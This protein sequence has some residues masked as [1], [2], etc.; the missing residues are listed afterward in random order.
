VR[1]VDASDVDGDFLRV[2]CRVI[3][4]RG[5]VVHQIQ[6]LAFCQE[7]NQRVIE[8]EVPAIMPDWMLLSSAVATEI[9]A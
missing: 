9:S 4:S 1:L 7:L 6:A 3:V 2:A 5:D 8:R